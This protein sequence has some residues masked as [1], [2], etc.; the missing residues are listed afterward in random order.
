ML[1]V[2]PAQDLPDGLDVPPAQDLPYAF[3]VPPDTGP[4]PERL[5]LDPASLTFFLL[6]I[7]STRAAVSGYDAAARACVT[8]VWDYSNT[9]HDL[10]PWCDEFG[11]GFP[12]VLVARDTDGPCGA[13]D[14][15][16]NVTAASASGCVQFKAL[17]MGAIDL[18]DVAI[19]VANESGGQTLIEAQNRSTFTPNPVSLGLRYVTDVPENVYIQTGDDYGLPSWAQVLGP[20][21]NA[22]LLF[23]QCDVPSCD[24]PGGGVCGIAFRQVRNVTGGT[25]SGQAWLT[26][27]G[28]FRVL[29]EAKGCRNA[30]AAAAGGYTLRVCFGWG[31]VDSA[32]GN[33]PDVKNPQ[34]HDVPFTLPDDTQVAFNANFGG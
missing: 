11:Q 13:W 3:D 34:C 32:G 30:V 28:R 16:P 22:R 27:D 33:G 19:T 5:V 12:Y 21:G 31:T 1:D 10:V 2:P 14:Y 8:I 18:V 9:G 24:N 17:G 26:W 15:G 29:D 7:D 20:D 4:L 6:P 23:D 25:Y